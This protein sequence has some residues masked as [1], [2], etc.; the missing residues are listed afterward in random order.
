MSFKTEK[1]ADGTKIPETMIHNPIIYDVINDVILQN[2]NKGNKKYNKQK[3]QL[4]PTSI[5]ALPISSTLVGEFVLAPLFF[6][7]SVF[8]SAFDNASHD[9]LLTLVDIGGGGMFPD[10]G[11]DDIVKAKKT[12]KNAEDAK[13]RLIFCI[14]ASQASLSVCIL[15][16]YVT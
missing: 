13:V 1:Y 8:W 10:V 9:A 11:W 15:I 12:K 4:T 3:E 16:T 5:L 2:F 14:S 7:A 6:D